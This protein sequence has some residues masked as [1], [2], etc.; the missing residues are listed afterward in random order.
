MIRRAL[1]VFATVLIGV[2]PFHVAS[3]QADKS[4]VFL[5]EI[6]Y[7][8]AS[9]GEYGGNTEKSVRTTGLSAGNGL[10]GARRLVLGSAGGWVAGVGTLGLL[11]YGID[12]V[13]GRDGGDLVVP[14]LALFGILIGSAAGAPLG[15]AWANDFE[16]N[17]VPGLFAGNILSGIA[18]YSA[19]HHPGSALYAAVGIP[20]IQIGVGAGLEYW[21]SR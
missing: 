8:E 13:S 4:A 18:L 1:A 10:G 19:V 20:I 15:A 16:G 17:L 11:G 2:A 9:L 12:A 7:T 21:T 14:E 6:G 3:A 5:P